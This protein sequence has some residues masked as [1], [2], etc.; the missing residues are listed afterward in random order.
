MDNVI[1]KISVQ[2][3]I[4]IKICHLNLPV[5]I[6]FHL[7]RHMPRFVAMLAIFIVNRRKVSNFIYFS[8]IYIILLFV[9]LLTAKV[10]N[11]KC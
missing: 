2:F 4:Y 10:N 9:F 7:V 8:F 3:Y 1:Y 5:V 11:T 6:S